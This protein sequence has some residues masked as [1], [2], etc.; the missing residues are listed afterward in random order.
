MLNKV[1]HVIG[2]GII[3]KPSE[4]ETKTT[5]WMRIALRGVERVQV[6][7]PNGGFKEI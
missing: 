7:E 1:R 3:R 5:I 6:L 4:Q 2:R